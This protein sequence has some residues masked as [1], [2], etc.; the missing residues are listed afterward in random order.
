MEKFVESEKVLVA[1]DFNGHVCSYMGGFGEVHGGFGIG[2]INDEWIRL[3]DWAVGK[4]MRLMNNFA[5]KRQIRLITF[6]LGEYEIMI[7]YILVNNKYR[8]RV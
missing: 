3:L 2:K 1:G 8:I 6:R 7:D 4:G 5:Q